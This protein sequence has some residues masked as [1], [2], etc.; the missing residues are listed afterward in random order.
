MLGDISSDLHHHRLHR[1]EKK[2]RWSVLLPEPQAG[3]CRSADLYYSS[4][5]IIQIIRE[6]LL[7]EKFCIKTDVCRTSDNTSRITIAHVSLL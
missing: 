2:H 3:P 1:H 5:K 7:F 4:S 6:E